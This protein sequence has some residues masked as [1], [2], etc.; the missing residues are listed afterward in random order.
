MPQPPQNTAAPQRT[1]WI[2]ITGAP[3]SGKTS[4]IND[5]KARGYDVQ[6]EVA[7]EYI[8]ACI[9]RGLSMQ[10]IRADGGMDL[11]RQILRLKT[12]REAVLSP[13]ETV[14]LDR[15][16]PDSMTYFRLAGL[17]VGAAREAAAYF[18]YDA[19]FLFDRLPVVNDGVRI[20]DEVLASEIDQM[21]MRDYRSLGYD[22]VRVPV[23]PI[24]KRTDFILNFL[25]LPVK[26]AVTP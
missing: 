22:P 20:E 6:D 7:R 5:L 17:D 3:S 13:K 14:F 10:D 11:Q 25:Q 1:E 9:S 26:R 16:I 15:G 24:A 4:V 2:V 19:V 12:A 23:M 21:L 18:L 8:E